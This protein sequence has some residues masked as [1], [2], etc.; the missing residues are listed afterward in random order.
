MSASLCPVHLLL[1]DHSADDQLVYDRLGKG[2]ADSFA[3]AIAVAV[4]R[5][6]GLVGGNVAA[7]LANRAQKLLLLLADG[8]AIE[9]CLQSVHEL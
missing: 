4:I 7:E 5:D 2:G 6:V 3:I 9:Y 8:V 1:L